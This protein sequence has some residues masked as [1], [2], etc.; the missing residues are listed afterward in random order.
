MA[1]EPP[2][3]GEPGISGQRATHPGFS[4]EEP[5]SS[6]RLKPGST[7]PGSADCDPRHTARARGGDAP[8]AGAASPLPPPPSRSPV[9]LCDLAGA[10]AQDAA[11]ADLDL[12]V[13]HDVVA[14]GGAESAA[15]RARLADEYAAVLARAGGGA[16]EVGSR[17]A[18]RVPLTRTNTAATGSPAVSALAAAFGENASIASQLPD[19][20]SG[21]AEG[22]RDDGEGSPHDRGSEDATDAKAAPLSDLP[23]LARAELAGAEDAVVPAALRAGLTPEAAA[24][25]GVRYHGLS[26]DAVG[27]AALLEFGAAY[28]TLR[29]MGF[30]A[31]VVT[32]ALR[33]ANNKPMAPHVATSASAT[34]TAATGPSAESITSTPERGSRS[35]T[36][37]PRSTNCRT[38]RSPPAHPPDIASLEG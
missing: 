7:R 19:V 35:R 20:P 21:D 37:S 32:G 38:P 8:A 26:A 24:M 2:A 29:E 22:A 12:G 30:G 1:F 33:L 14:G 16:S 5:G 31:A 17:A 6:V 34:T 18:Q 36:F 28:G 9:G 15:V 23:E 11:V 27:E 4:D 25:A 13:E 3:S 10:V